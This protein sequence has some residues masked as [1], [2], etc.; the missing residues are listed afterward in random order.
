MIAALLLSLIAGSTWSWDPATGAD[1]YRLYWSFVH[2]C[3]I[4]DRTYSVDVG[5]DT[6]YDD[7][8]I[9]HLTTPQPGVITYWV[10]TAYNSAGESSTEHGPILDPAEG[11]CLP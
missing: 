5:P 7:F 3:C 11:V 2:P 9:E 6:F 4:W 8:P 1:G 10:V